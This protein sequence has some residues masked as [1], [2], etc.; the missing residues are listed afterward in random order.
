MAEFQRL[1]GMDTAL[2]LVERPPVN[3]NIG[4][5]LVF[6]HLDATPEEVTEHVASRLHR[7]PRF[8]KRLMQ[9]PYG[10]GRPVWVDDEHFDI[11]FHVRHIGLG[12]TRDEAALLDLFGRLQGMPLDRSRPLWELWIVDLPDGRHAAIQKVHHAMVDGVSDVDVLVA[13]LDL[14]RDWATEPASAWQ[15][16]APPSRAALLTDSAV[17]SGRRTVTALGA[18]ISS[19]LR[20]PAAAIERVTQTARAAA[21]T[22]GAVARPVPETS[23]GAQIGSRRRF[24]VVRLDLETLKDTKSRH[25]TTV[26]DVAL[27][28]TA[29]GLGRLLAHRGEGDADLRLETVVPMS[30]RPDAAAGTLGNR[31]APLRIEL[32]VGTADPAEILAD[33]HAQM[34]AIK[35][36]KALPGGDVLLD[37]TELLPTTLISLGVRALIDRQHVMTLMVTNVPGPQFPLFFRG[38]ELLEIFP[39]VPILQNTTLGVAIA[40]YN[41][42]VVF[43][44]TGDWD[45]TTDIDVLTEGIAKAL[46]DL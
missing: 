15:P 20:H 36:S 19:A 43:G 13:L 6:E 8:R 9:L 29:Y 32:P 45:S 7:L 27:A 41:G 38:S 5:L 33:V 4:A 28:A 16:A 39:C 23:I 46:T 3:M 12:G 2:L 1:S 10:L 40:S 17:E 14:G 37:A 35:S 42:K 34:E 24:A 21:A 44:I 25:G 11:H 31:F 22:F 30:V 18:G 26:N